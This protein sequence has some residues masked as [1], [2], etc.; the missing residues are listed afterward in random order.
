MKPGS[1]PM[2]VLAIASES[3]PGGSQP[4]SHNRSAYSNHSARI[5]AMAART[6]TAASSETKAS[7]HACGASRSGPS[8]PLRLTISVVSSRIP[9][10]GAAASLLRSVAYFDGAAP[11]A[12]LLAWAAGGVALLG[13]GALRA[14]QMTTPTASPEPVAVPA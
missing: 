6:G 9:P 12:V 8:G 10:P 13:L 4:D 5:D 1:N 3:V 7:A 11:L 2:S 14:R